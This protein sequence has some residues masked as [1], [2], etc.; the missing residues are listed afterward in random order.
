MLAIRGQ[1]TSLPVGRIH[2]V[3]IN[4]LGMPHNPFSGACVVILFSNCVRCPL[5]ARPTRCFDLNPA[6]DNL[7][8]MLYVVCPLAFIGNEPNL[9]GHDPRG[10]KKYG[11]RATHHLPNKFGKGFVAATWPLLSI[12]HCLWARLNG[13]RRVRN[14]YFCS[15]DGCNVHLIHFHMPIH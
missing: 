2:W 8:A 7:S 15:P 9:S 3:C 6:P 4:P 12:P 1:S 14:A 11:Q 13:D 10:Q 5:P